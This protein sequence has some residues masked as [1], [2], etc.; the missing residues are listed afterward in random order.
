M[1]RS[2]EKALIPCAA[3]AASLLLFGAFVAAAGA[4]PLDVYYDMYRGGFGTWFSFQNTLQRAA[5]LMLTA[6]CALIPAHLGLI[7]IG[8]EGAL[9][10]G[11]LGAVIAGRLFG[12][13]PPMVASTLM[14]LAGGAV[15][16]LW[17]ALSGALRA[18]RGVNETISSLLLNY[19]A[20]ALFNHLVEGPLRDP[21]SL[22]KPSTFPIAD[23]SAIGNIPGMDVHWGLVFGLVACGLSYLMVMHSVHGFAARMI[24]GN[25]RAAALSG[26]SVA[27]LTIALCF[28]AG[29]C[30]GM[31]G[32]VEVGAVHH[33]ANATLIAGYG[34]MGVLVAFLARQHPLAAIPV[35]LLLGG[36]NASG[37]L[38][39]R[40]EHLP[41]A[42]VKVLQ[43]ILFVVILASE[44]LYG[45]WNWSRV[46]PAAK[47]SA[48]E[49]PSEGAEPLAPAAEAEPAQVKGIA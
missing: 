25:V 45:R 31:A 22:N 4:N 13:A 17:I 19:I 46:R 34:Y 15:G 5:P 10:L 49:N 43:G 16:G 37:G 33:T 3:L 42:T 27:R 21:A 18:L 12:S 28:L 30:A 1:G 35:S 9:L 14:M 41:D 20:I 2:L 8:G 24:G 29:A 47:G 44:T 38:L 7:V 26:I 40:T 32:A 39:Q 48:L 11:A 36:I 23:A 6:L